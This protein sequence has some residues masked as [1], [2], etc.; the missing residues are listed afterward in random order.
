[1]GISA[2]FSGG[3]KL[4][5]RSGWRI[6]ADV[7]LLILFAIIRCLAA[8]ASTNVAVCDQSTCL[9]PFPIKALTVSPISISYKTN[10]RAT[11]PVALNQHKN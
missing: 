5:S 7:F 10:L 2:D 3:L 6:L 11:E 4:F 1:M 9:I 8:M